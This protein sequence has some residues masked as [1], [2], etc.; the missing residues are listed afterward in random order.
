MFGHL[1]PHKSIFIPSKDTNVTC[2][3]IP[4][5]EAAQVPSLPSGTE[6]LPLANNNLINEIAL[7]DCEGNFLNS[8][9]EGKCLQISLLLF[10]S[11]TYVSQYVTET[12]C[13]TS[14]WEISND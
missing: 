3:F 14:V 10:C 5:E 13:H 4:P 8:D 7:D 6:N 2:S 1:G 11:D 12:W 9:P